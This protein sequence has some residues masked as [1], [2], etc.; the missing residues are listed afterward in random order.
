M[1]PG[2]TYVQ[3]GGGLPDQLLPPG[4]K[5]WYGEHGLTLDHHTRVTWDTATPPPGRRRRGGAPA[6]RGTLSTLGVPTPAAL[7]ACPDLT[8]PAVTPHR[9][10]TLN[11]VL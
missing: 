9:H 5:L 11:A 4:V 8:L 10:E 3:P 1:W 6:G 2:C 7:V